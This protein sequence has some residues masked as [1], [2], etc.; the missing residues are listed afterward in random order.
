MVL[1]FAEQFVITTKLYHLWAV[2]CDLL[3]QLFF[4]LII[5]QTIVYIVLSL[6]IHYQ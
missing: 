3:Y 4:S 5:P 1:N 2:Q 6:Y